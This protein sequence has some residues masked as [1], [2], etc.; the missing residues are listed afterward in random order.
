MTSTCILFTV[1]F[2]FLVTKTDIEH[3]TFIVCLLRH[4]LFNESEILVEIFYNHLDV[5][6]LK[7]L[8]CVTVARVL[9]TIKFP[10]FQS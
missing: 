1:L 8:S 2:V 4:D 9:Q 5:D 6:W 7:G 3:I 10:V